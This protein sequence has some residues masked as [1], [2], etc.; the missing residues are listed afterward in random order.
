MAADDARSAP[1]AAEMLTMGR[2]ARAASVALARL[3]P[4][5]RTAALTAMA[6]EVRRNADAILAANALDMAAAHDKGLAGPMLDRLKLTPERL[7]AMAAGVEAVAALP[8]PVGKVLAEW[9]RPNGLKIARVTQPLGVVAIIYESRPNVT[10]DAGALCVRAGDAA[11]LR[12][13]SESAHT[14]RAIADALRAGLAGTGAPAD[15]IQLVRTTDRAAV[16]HILSGLD[17][18]VDVI[19]PRGGKSL[20]ARVQAEA[21]APVI[22]HLEG[23][24]HTYVHA[25]ADPEKA[26]AIVANAKLRRTGVCGSTETLLID[27]AVAP[28]LLP[29]IRDALEAKGGCA[30][31]GD[32]AARAILPMQAATEEDFRT[33][34]LDAILNVRV[35]DELDGALEHIR[36]YGT[37]HTAAI[38]T[39]DA[40]AADRFLNETDS[41]IVMWNA[42]TQFA[43]GGEF[44][45]GAEI[46]IAT[47]RIHARGPV[48]ADQLVTFRYQVRG[49]GQTRP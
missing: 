5:A 23:L 44:G 43:D 41:A 18:A 1:L 30:L 25:G 6:A 7:E 26:T 27:A 34:H 16:G 48:G 36:T 4:A 31:R 15:A 11:I 10:A 40:A 29:A 20:V 35:V 19:V 2:R 13:G 12:G 37:G 21:K 28:S 33:E 14:S 42:S 22:G 32:A 3:D 24:C 47:G 8:D 9:E 38:V 39:E 49:T 46:G 17:G 45:M